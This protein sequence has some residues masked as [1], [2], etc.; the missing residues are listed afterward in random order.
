MSYF[1][2]TIRLFLI[3]FVSFTFCSFS[4]FSFGLPLSFAPAFAILIESAFIVRILDL[5]PWLGPFQELVV[6]LRICY[7]HPYS[8]SR[9]FVKIFSA[10]FTIISFFFQAILARLFSPKILLD[11]LKDHRFHPFFLLLI[12]VSSS[13]EVALT[14]NFRQSSK[15]LS[16]R[17]FS[18]HSHY[19]FAKSFQ[20]TYQD[21]FPI[22]K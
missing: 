9:R 16:P 2:F 17:L 15:F 5:H 20:V 18:P 8:R 4:A 1:R 3:F 11:L 14:R 21:T 7:L 19:R 12:D 6:L 10:F 22:F 13:E